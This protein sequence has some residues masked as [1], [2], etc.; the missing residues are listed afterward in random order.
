MNTRPHYP[1]T[2]KDHSYRWRRWRL[3]TQTILSLA[4]NSNHQVLRAP[5][6]AYLATSRTTIITSVYV[7]FA[8]HI[9][10]SIG[11]WYGYLTSSPVTSV[12]PGLTDTRPNLPR[13]FSYPDLLGILRQKVRWSTRPLFCH[14]RPKA[15][16]LKHANS[17]KRLL[18][19]E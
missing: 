1:Q 17:P 13:V 14:S 15:Q 12:R 8:A 5:L 7:V 2:N 10:P 16:N 11:C 3:R 9:R 4:D 18:S 6:R 19:N